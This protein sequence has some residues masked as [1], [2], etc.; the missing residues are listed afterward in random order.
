MAT[1]YSF[2]SWVEEFNPVIN[3]LDDNASFQDEDG[4]GIMF[5]TYGD[6]LEYVLL[7]DNHNVWTY[8]DS[9]EGGT[10]ICAGYH[11]V[12]RIGYFI[13]QKPWTSDPELHGED[14][15]CITIYEND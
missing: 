13:T 15:I 11:I 5:E 8:M 6:E 1:D 4:V 9:D 3:H 2:E 12:G 14:H 10:I 7:Q